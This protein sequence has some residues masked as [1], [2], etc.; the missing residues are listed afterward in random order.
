[1]SKNYSLSALQKKLENAEK[2]LERLKNHRPNGTTTNNRCKSYMK[3]L[4]ACMSK[5]D[6]LQR[7]VGL[8]ESTIKYIKEH[9]LV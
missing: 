8:V 6:K 4:Y 5:V 7:A 9:G 1:M 3:K 2:K